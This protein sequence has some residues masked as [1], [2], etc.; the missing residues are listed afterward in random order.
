MKALPC[1]LLCAAARP[2]RPRSSRGSEAASE[3]KLYNVYGPTETIIDSTYWPCEERNADSAIP[4]GRPIPNA[5]VYILDDLLRLLP[6]GVAGNLYIGGVGLARGY[7]RRPD[8]TAEKFIPDPFSGEPGARL[9]K[10]GDLARYR[11][12]GNIEFLGRSDH[13]VKIRGFRIEL[14]E[15][16][17]TLGQ[18]PAVREAIV[19][20]QEDGSGE[21]RL[22]AYVA[23]EEEAR[24][25]ANELR[26]F[27]KDK[28]PEHMVPAVF[29]LLDAFPLTAN[30]KVDRRALPTPEG[31]RPELDEAFV[32]CRTPTEELLAD[33]WRQVLGVERVGIYDN[34][35]QLGG[36][37]LLATQVVSR[38]REAFQVEMPL[39]RLFETPTVAGLAESIEG[40][41]GTGLQAPPI[42][43]VPRDGEL[44][45]SFAQQRLWFIDQLEPGSSV[46]NFPAAVR[47]KGPLNLVALKQ[48]LNEIVKRHEACGR[49]LPLWMVDQFR[50]SHRS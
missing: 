8:L 36:H 39:R 24:P 7:V 32:A 10:T 28:L 41:R 9:Y 27:L 34:F 3:A 20:V 45:L 47:L 33:I 19:Q 40:G 6:I 42:V 48:S 25:T 49:P 38:I 21:K 31:R 14:G 44:P 15:I 22:V 16:E 17:G 23:A 1:A 30:G 29:V 11:P 18:H 2:W 35:F 4:I 5:R 12:D 37:S 13:Q 50:L 43:P 46:Y 26:G